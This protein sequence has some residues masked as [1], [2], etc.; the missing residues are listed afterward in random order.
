MRQPGEVG[1]AVVNRLLMLRSLGDGGDGLAPERVVETFPAVEDAVF[2][3]N[4]AGV[5]IRAG[6][7]ARR[8]R[9]YQVVDF[10]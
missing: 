6:V 10:S 9:G 1:E 3:E 5:I 2:G 7:R 8:V 4:G